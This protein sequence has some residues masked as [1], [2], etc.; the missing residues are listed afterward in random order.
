MLELG[1]P[2]LSACVVCVRFSLFFSLFFSLSLCSLYAREKLNGTQPRRRFVG[3]LFVAIDT[4]AFTPTSS[5]TLSLALPS[6]PVTKLSAILSAFGR[7]TVEHFSCDYL[8]ILRKKRIFS[9][10]I[11]LI[12]SVFFSL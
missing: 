7:R 3:I 10:V 6:L 11:Y 5:L 8:D 1:N 12:H 9:S 2:M 4:N